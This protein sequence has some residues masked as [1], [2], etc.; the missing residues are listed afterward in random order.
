MSAFSDF[1]SQR[2][3]HVWPGV[4]ARAIHGE[5]MTVAMVDL[6]PGA[7]VAEHHHE[8]EQLGFVVQGS[9][10]MKIGDETRLLGPGDTYSIPSDVPHSVLRA[11]PDGCVVV[12]VFAPVRADWEAIERGDPSP[13]SWPPR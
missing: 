2:P 13:G 3:Y 5:R 6:D 8:N 7:P 10:E 1:K 12:D 4:V 9:M 11:G